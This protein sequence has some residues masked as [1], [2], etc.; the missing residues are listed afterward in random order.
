[1]TRTVHRLMLL[2]LLWTTACRGG[3][4][5]SNAVPGTTRSTPQIVIGF[6]TPA[7]EPAV[8]A[9]RM[10]TAPATPLVVTTSVT[11]T[12]I[13]KETVILPTP[14]PVVIT[15]TP[16][17]PTLAPTGTPPPAVGINCDDGLATIT[18]PPMNATI[19]GTVPFTG[20]ANT[21]DLLFYKLQYMPDASWG[22]ERWGELYRSSDRVVNGKLM[23]WQTR[24]VEPGVYWVRLL[25]TRSN[26]QYGLPCTIRVTVVR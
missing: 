16:V 2:T 1:M 10:R 8:T 11:Q 13:V 23:E 26:G 19:R 22:S 5:A 14:R 4:P 18:S 20:T 15:T 9:T 12:V 6:A 24:T 21:A 25:A 17:L 7:G 3:V